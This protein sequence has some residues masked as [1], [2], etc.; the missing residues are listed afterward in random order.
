MGLVTSVSYRVKINGHL[1]LRGAIT[2]AYNLGWNKIIM[3]YDCL[4]LIE[5][6]KRERFLAGIQLLV[7]DILT[8]AAEFVHHGFTWV[9]RSGNEVAHNIAKAYASGSLSPSWICTNP[10]W[11]HSLLARD[12][13]TPLVL[14]PLA[15]QSSNEPSEA[16][17]IRDPPRSI[18]HDL[19]SH[20][21]CR[22][23]I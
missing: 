11:L 3:E 20:T 9:R 8:V 17:S 2:I 15:S 7:A 22:S 23:R 16:E 21:L 4:L 12:R 18:T 5:A 13:E 19:I 1:T 6:C 14:N 10:P